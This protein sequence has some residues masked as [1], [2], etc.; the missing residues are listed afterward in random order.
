MRQQICNM[1]DKHLRAS[2]IL[3]ASGIAG[4]TPFTRV[5]ASISQVP[6]ILIP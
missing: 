4:I 2:G 6:H 3:A 1:P 5:V